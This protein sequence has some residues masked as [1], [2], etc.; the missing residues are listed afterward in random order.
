[1]LPWLGM[2]R[3]NRKLVPVPAHVRKQTARPLEEERLRQRA[4]ELRAERDRIDLELARV[5]GGVVAHPVPDFDART[6]VTMIDPEDV[7]EFRGL[8]SRSASIQLANV[9][10]QVSTLAAG[11]ARLEAHHEAL[12]AKLDGML[13]GEVDDRREREKERLAREQRAE[14]ARIDLERARAAA[15]ADDRRAQRQGEADSAKQAAEL[16]K[17]NAGYR[18]RIL[19]QVV[20]TLGGI[21]AGAFALVRFV[22]SAG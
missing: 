11:L 12:D 16:R 10:A 6:P 21:I 1:M 8:R 14:A 20:L 18:A 7:Q 9:T 2:D 5:D 4:A 15:E 13:R 22:A 19:L 3:D 17:A